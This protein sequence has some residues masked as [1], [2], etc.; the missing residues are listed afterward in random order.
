MLGQVAN[1]REHGKAPVLDL[2]QSHL[3][4]VKA[5]R[6]E[7]NHVQQATLHSSALCWISTSQTRYQDIHHHSARNSKQTR[8]YT[9]QHSY[10]LLPMDAL[11]DIHKW[12]LCWATVVLQQIRIRSEMRCSTTNRLRKAQCYN[13]RA[14]M[15][16]SVARTHHASLLDVLVALELESTNHNCLNDGKSGEVKGGLLHTLINAFTTVIGSTSNTPAQPGAVRA[17]S[18][19]A[20][21]YQSPTSLQSRRD[22]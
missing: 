7:G 19:V 15:G 4:A 17:R 12:M 3:L 9:R 13:R 21:W 11:L 5:N 2:G 6:V 8:V 14:V 1:K 10:G 20:P 22:P 18:W 16:T